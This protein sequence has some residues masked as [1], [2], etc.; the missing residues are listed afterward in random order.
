MSTATIKASD[1]MYDTAS[2]SDLTRLKISRSERERA[3]L[4]VEEF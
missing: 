3:W 2:I 4:W 1:Q